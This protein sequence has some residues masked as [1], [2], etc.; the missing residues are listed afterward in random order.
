MTPI[1]TV[2]ALSIGVNA[3]MAW[4]SHLAASR[5]AL[6]FHMRT[7]RSVAI[8]G[9]ALL[10]QTAAGSSQSNHMVSAMLIVALAAAAV[11]AITDA[12][13]GY[14][15]DA[16]TLPA[17]GILVVLSALGDTLPAAAFGAAACGSALLVLYAI[18]G[19]RGLGLGDVKLACII[20]AALGVSGGL[21][22]IGVAFVMGGVYAGALLATRRARRGD[23][24]RF[25]PFLAGGLALVS[26]YQVIA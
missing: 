14:V 26:V 5:Y 9:F 12:G 10:V 6:P 2:L 25:A 15:F 7:V 22:S 24:V 17:L 21:I 20:G 16:V 11:C 1:G 8:L 18:T 19:G 13:T 23:E 4:L 3:L